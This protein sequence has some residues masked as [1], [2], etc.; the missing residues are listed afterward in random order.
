MGRQNDDEDDEGGTGLPKTNAHSSKIPNKI[1]KAVPAFQ[2]QSAQGEAA[3]DFGQ[4]LHASSLPPQ[5]H[6]PDARAHH[7]ATQFSQTQ[8]GSATQPMQSQGKPL[9]AYRQKKLQEAQLREQ[10]ITPIPGKRGRKRL[11]PIGVDAL[12]ASLQK[13]KTSQPASG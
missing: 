10:G 6:S 11:N 4:T 9:S 8:M 5:G 3:F 12:A 2:S 1:L 7:S 13:E